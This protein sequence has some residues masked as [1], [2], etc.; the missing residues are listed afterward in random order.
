MRLTNT[1]FGK[2]FLHNPRNCDRSIMLHSRV[3]SLILMFMVLTT[4]HGVMAQPQGQELVTNGGFEMGMQGWTPVNAF[5]VTSTQQ[6]YYDATT[7]P[8]HSGQY[9]AQVGSVYQPGTLSQTVTI[10]SKSKARFT[11]WYR[12]EQGA[13]ITILLKASDGSTIQ[14][15]AGSGSGWTTV[16][17]DLNPSY[18]GQSITIEFDGQGNAVIQ[19][20]VG[21]CGYGRFGFPFYCT[22]QSESDYFAFVDDVSVIATLAQYTSSVN[23][24]GIPTELSTKLYVDGTQVG[25]LSGEQSQE[26]AFSIGETHMVSVDDPIYR[27]NTTRYYCNSSSITVTTDGQVT[28]SYQK[29]Y[30]LTVNSPYGTTVGTGWS[31]EGSKVMFSVP[32]DRLPMPG[33]LGTL[34]AKYT[35]DKW[36]G[37]ETSNNLRSFTIIDGPKSVTATWREDYTMLYVLI[38]VVV[39]ALIAGVFGYRKLAEERVK[40]QQTAVYEDRGGVVID[41]SR[42]EEEPTR[43]KE[44]EST[45]V[46]EESEKT[47]YRNQKRRLKEK[48]ENTHD[49]KE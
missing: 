3:W 1:I 2:T 15:W 21:I 39:L 9:S 35:F 37:D 4:I 25:T 46:A 12:L 43:I 22:C 44:D 27:D 24:A 40:R 33:L 38:V 30:Y 16:S 19:P 7:H 8:P 29:Q 18:A 42:A 20:Y 5:A 23:V 31:D 11:A 26:L 34:G 28:F 47:K 45:Q 41:V 13:S 36:V 6:G 17:Y 10:P 14:N 49:M 32:T 48:T